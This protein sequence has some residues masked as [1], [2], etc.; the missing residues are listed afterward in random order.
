MGQA[1]QPLSVQDLPAATHATL[2][3][4]PLYSV[5]PA[6][7]LRWGYD[8]GRWSSATGRARRLNASPRIPRLKADA[9]YTDA[10]L[11][12]IRAAGALSRELCHVGGSGGGRRGSLDARADRV[13]R[14]PGRPMRMVAV[15]D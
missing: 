12:R 2:M 15:R 14:S 5:V 7:D 3:A 1:V 9:T 13:G 8:G 4:S 6:T 10:R 11:S